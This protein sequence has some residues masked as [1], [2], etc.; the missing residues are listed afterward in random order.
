MDSPPNSRCPVCDY[1][2]PGIGSNSNYHCEGCGSQ[3][4]LGIEDPKGKQTPEWVKEQKRLHKL[5]AEE[6]CAWLSTSI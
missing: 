4:V 5:A 3:I 1:P 2:D 6:Y